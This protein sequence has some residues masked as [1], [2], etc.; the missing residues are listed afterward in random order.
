MKSRIA[1]LFTVVA[2]LV[3]A[4]PVSA[5]PAKPVDAITVTL[6]PAD[7]T[8]ESLR[9][10]VA[11]FSKRIAEVNASAEA[12]REQLQKQMKDGLE[13]AIAKAQSAGDID[14]VLA[15]KAAKEQFETLATSNVPL[16]KNAIDYREKKT[17]EFETA[18]VSDALKAAKE[19]ND[20]LEKSKKEETTK[21]NFDTAKA[22][23]DY[24]K[25]LLGWCRSIQ[26]QA[27]Q[28]QSRPVAGEWCNEGE[29][30]IV[31][32]AAT[33]GRGGL[34]G[35]ARKGD[36]FIIRY[37]DG[38]WTCYKG[39][40]P[41]ESPDG[42]VQKDLHRAVVVDAKDPSRIFAVVPSNTSFTPFEFSVPED[43]EFS[44]RMNDH[45]FKDN[46]GQV[47]Y[48]AKRQ[49]WKTGSQLQRFKQP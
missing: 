18:R 19:F 17:A 24:Q 25:E 30:R 29:P 43:A 45:H 44:L 11:A 6:L 28:T 40:L 9:K 21:G 31:V 10:M 37:E 32:V 23:S 41:K 34:I 49:I 39:R 5:V 36:R 48:T 14:T 7:G 8:P 47:R 42:N 1:I 13:K 2:A 4:S 16:V 22:L 3:A 20:E 27:P 15:L 38:T 33:D 46:S 35:D 26:A 12:K